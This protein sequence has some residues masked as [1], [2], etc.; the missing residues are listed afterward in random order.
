MAILGD[1]TTFLYEKLYKY[2]FLFLKLLHM[3]TFEECVN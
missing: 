1:F 2:S 3:S